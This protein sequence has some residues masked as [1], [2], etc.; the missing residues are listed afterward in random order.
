MN[1]RSKGQESGKVSY[2][3]LVYAQQALAG[4]ET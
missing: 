3:S 2:D 1:P 4:V